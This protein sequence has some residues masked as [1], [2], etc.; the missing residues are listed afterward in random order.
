MHPLDRGRAGFAIKKYRRYGNLAKNRIADGVQ[1]FSA[2]NSL[3][4]R[5]FCKRVELSRDLRIISFYVQ[6]IDC[7]IDQHWNTKGKGK[8]F[9]RSMSRT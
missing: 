9:C 3:A 7:E 2:A 4:T 1:G 5:S 8:R 6:S